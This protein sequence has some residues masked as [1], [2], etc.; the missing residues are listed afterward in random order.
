M[1]VG[2]T[3]SINAMRLVG[4]VTAPGVNFIPF[5]NRDISS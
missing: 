1:L 2:A 4:P 5:R 3:G